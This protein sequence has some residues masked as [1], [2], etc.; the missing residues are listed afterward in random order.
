MVLF[1]A[2]LSPVIVR[3]QVQEQFTVPRVEQ[4][5][6]HLVAAPA[7]LTL[8]VFAQPEL[9]VRSPFAY[10]HLGLFCK[11]EYHLHRWLPVRVLIR[12]GDV[13]QDEAVDGKGAGRWR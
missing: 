1:A 2:A 4:P 5:W 13:A 9:L 10:E 7:P 12:I 8:D 11:A 3:A 6:M